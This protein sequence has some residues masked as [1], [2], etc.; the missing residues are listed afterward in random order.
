MEH[1][2]NA[3]QYSYEELCK[4]TEI[5]LLRLRCNTPEDIEALD[6]VMFGG[7][8]EYYLILQQNKILQ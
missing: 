6:K 2:V 7:K 3:H 5:Q 8:R 1:R 4:M